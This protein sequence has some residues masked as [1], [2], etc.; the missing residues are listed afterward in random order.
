MSERMW[1]VQTPDGFAYSFIELDDPEVLKNRYC[2]CGEGTDE[3]YT[4]SDNIPPWS[5]LEERGYSV[6]KV[7]VREVDV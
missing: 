1:I 4:L 2:H 7:E 6:V 5:W 3:W